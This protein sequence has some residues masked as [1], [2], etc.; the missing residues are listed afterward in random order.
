[1]EFVRGEREREF[2]FSP[3]RPRYEHMTIASGGDMSLRLRGGS[4]RQ[5]VQE[6]LIDIQFNIQLDG[7][8]A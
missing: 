4:N 2:C 6:Y 8:D 5:V 3:V 7:A 1:M